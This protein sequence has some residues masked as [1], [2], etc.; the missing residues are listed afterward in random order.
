MNILN[1]LKNFFKKE[2]CG[3]YS[4][5][6]CM[7]FDDLK[8]FIE[9]VSE[10]HDFDNNSL[11]YY[12]G[13]AKNLVNL[14]TSE[15]SR[16]E[17]DIPSMSLEYIGDCHAKNNNIIFEDVICIPDVVFDLA[18]KY[19][20]M[21]PNKPCHCLYNSDTTGFHQINKFVVSRD[22]VYLCSK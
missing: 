16:G 22:N 7:K 5:N 18:N 15:Y 19:Y 6:F 4:K 21:D 11:Y 20:F 10:N 1:K 17:K 12:L 8:S 13:E 2:N 3:I 14:I 9:Y